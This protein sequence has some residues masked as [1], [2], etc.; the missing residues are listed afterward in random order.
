MDGLSP[1]LMAARF[2]CVD[3]LR[4]FRDWGKAYLHVT[5]ATGTGGHFCGK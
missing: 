1:V 3:V 5:M 4:E 2:G